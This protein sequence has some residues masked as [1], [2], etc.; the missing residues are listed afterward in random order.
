MMNSWKLF[1]KELKSLTESSNS[2]QIFNLKAQ[3]SY[4]L[5]DYS[6]CFKHLITNFINNFNSGNISL[7]K[8]LT[9]LALNETRQNSNSVGNDFFL[10]LLSIS[11]SMV[12][13]LDQQLQAEQEN[14]A[15]TDSLMNSFHT[16]TFLNNLALV[17]YSL[18]KYSLST[19]YFKKSLS[20]NLKLVKKYLTNEKKF[21]KQEQILI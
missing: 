10:N 11:H 3:E 18:R 8:S 15:S 21:L 20:E 7:K 5:N 12:N 4:L 13:S 14:S 2:K 16:I 1:D 19:L 17:H 9:D 6:S